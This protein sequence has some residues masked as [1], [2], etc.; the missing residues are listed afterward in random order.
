MFDVEGSG[1]DS[2]ARRVSGSHTNQ[3]EFDVFVVLAA[4]MA[5]TRLGPPLGSGGSC[6]S[7][8]AVDPSGAS[9]PGSGGGRCAVPAGGAAPGARPFPPLPGGGGGRRESLPPPP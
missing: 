6:T 7:V 2:P 1:D 5:T 3:T 8:E 4:A 9:I